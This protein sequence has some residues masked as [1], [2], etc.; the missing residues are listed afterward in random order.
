MRFHFDFMKWAKVSI[1][2]SLVVTLVGVISLATRGINLSVDYT[3]GTQMELQ[4]DKDLT[5]AEVRD[6]VSTLS[7]KSPTVKKAELKGQ[8]TG[9]EFLI[10]TPRLTDEERLGLVEKLKEQ[11]AT[12]VEIIA[13]NDVSG[14]IRA[15][16]IQEALIALAIASVFQ[17]I[18]ITLRFEY[19][20]GITA[21]VALLHDALI[22]LGLVSLLGI[23]VG[24]AFVAAVLTVVGYSVNDTIIIFDRIRENLRTKAKGESL[25]A[26]VNR[27]LNETLVRSLNTTLT[28]LVVLGSIM[29]LGGDTTRDFATTLFIG[30]TS[31]AY[32]SIFIAAPIWFWWKN[33]SKKAAASSAAR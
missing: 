16:L 30:I 3:G 15:E 9:S 22:T 26:M 7:G 12:E 25:P 5:V 33:A 21:V 32:S 10:T 8:A 11:L 19:R 18:Y 17:V 6:A 29:I 4:F 2:I 28:T 23:E 20:F 27:S 31:G 14:T 24:P 1:G 13:V